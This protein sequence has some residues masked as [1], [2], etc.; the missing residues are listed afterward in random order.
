[1]NSSDRVSSEEMREFSYG[2][3]RHLKK[4]LTDRGHRFGVGRTNIAL[5]PLIKNSGFMLFWI[6]SIKH[7]G[8]LM[9]TRSQREEDALTIDNFWGIKSFP[10]Q[11]RDLVSFPAELRAAA[12]IYEDVGNILEEK[13]GK[14]IG[15]HDGRTIYRAKIKQEAAS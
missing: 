4:E 3:G 8:E 2:L 11:T 14:P 12:K 13:F 10:P 1:M 9:V 7:G 6:Y 5:S 15:D